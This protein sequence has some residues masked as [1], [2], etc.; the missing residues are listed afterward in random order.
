MPGTTRDIRLD[1]FRGLALLFI[2]MD[3]IPG[4]AF[5]YLTLANIVF[6]DAA[7]IFVFISG[8]TA[9]AVFGA[10]MRR[11]GVVFAGVQILRRGWTLYIAHIFVFV[12]F[13]AQVSWTAQRFANPMFVDE[14]NV[15][16]FLQEPHIAV[17]EALILRFQ[18]AF[19]NILPLYIVL[20]V[21]LAV[22]LP[23]LRDN[24]AA[25]LGIAGAI[26]LAEQLFHFNL[27]TYP[28]GVW[29]FNPFAWQALFLIGAV[30]GFASL[31]GVPRFL[32]RRQFV[33]VSAAFLGLAVAVK[34]PLTVFDL[35]EISPGP[36]A[37]WI[38]MFA[39]KTNLGPLRLLN[40]LALAHVT[41]AVL[42]RDHAAF[43]SRWAAP[44]VCCGQNSLDIFCLGIF[45]SYFAHLALVETEH[46]LAA[47][48]SV[49]VV[50]ISVM[51]AAAQFLNWSKARPRIQAV[52]ATSASEKAPQG[53]E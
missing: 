51:F 6:S 39:D 11:E 47:Q 19:M 31:D 27:S 5:S 35:L 52:A 16:S 7:E 24:R 43:R 25:A 34:A 49:N 10:L 28:D 36:L 50:G 18:P 13:T 21:G 15:A 9:A 2:F 29:F 14:M 12:I 4:N 40:F 45:L 26:Y 41:V 3:H 22:L 8:Y 30:L 38:W 48:F 42:K 17:F 53:G 46:S 20:L 37:G 44:V 1:F 23:V 33:L 32:G